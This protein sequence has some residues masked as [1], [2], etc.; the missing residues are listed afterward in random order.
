MPT[1]KCVK[2]GV[3]TQTYWST[4][5][6]SIARSKTAALIFKT[7]K[8]TPPHNNYIHYAE[9]DL[10]IADCSHCL[11]LLHCDVYCSVYC[12]HRRCGGG[13]VQSSTSGW[14]KPSWNVLGCAQFYRPR[15]RPVCLTH[16]YH[17]GHSTHH[18]WATPPG[19]M[20]GAMSK[21][22]HITESSPA[23]AFW[24]VPKERWSP[25]VWLAHAHAHCAQQPAQTSERIDFLF[26]RTHVLFWM[27]HD[28]SSPQKHDC[29]SG[30]LK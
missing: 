5:L 2:E 27:M 21:I 19:A 17:M 4:C 20:E 15:L 23:G 22:G 13:R 26:A 12:C 3:C 28:V 9:W 16:P 11:P 18:T 25:L 24:D 14:D 29:R 30:K 7:Y 8:V 10:L 1:R 6:K